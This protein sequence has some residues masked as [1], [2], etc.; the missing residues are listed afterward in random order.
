MHILIYVQDEPA[1]TMNLQYTLAILSATEL[2][3]PVS[4]QEPKGASFTLATDKPWDTL[5]AQLLAK[6][7]SALQPCIISFA[8]Y[9]IK[10]QISRVLLK[11]G[12][13]L[14]CEEDYADLVD[15]SHNIKSNPPTININI[16]PISGGSG[17]D[18]NKENEEE[19]SSGK[20]K[21]VCVASITIIAVTE[22]L[23]QKAQI[24]PEA[25]PGNVVKN[26][27]IQLLQ[28][29]WK[30][31]WCQDSCIGVHC[32]PDPETDAHLPLNHEWLDC[33]ATTM[34]CC[35]SALCSLHD[36]SFILSLDFCFIFYILLP[37]FLPYPNS[38]ANS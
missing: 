17:R 7:D 10:Y 5:K 19:D 34:V 15:H 20:T 6:I 27:N 38:F 26:K 3:K 29:Q 13:D 35:G 18:N 24:D 23:Y 16:Q 21:K 12:L 2:K 11:P 36:A 1:M 33:W 30:C 31:K 28:E 25:L 32:Y 9:Q 8:D 4:W 14:S 37:F 22:S